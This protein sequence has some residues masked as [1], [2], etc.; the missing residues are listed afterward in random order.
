MPGT[1]EPSEWVRRWSH[2]VPVHGTVLDVACGQGRHM[3][4]F[5]SRGHGAVGIDRDPQALEA[6][7]RFGE[8]IAAD[9][10]NAAWPLLKGG[11][12][13]RFA[14]LVVTH[15]LWRRLWPTLLLSLEP[16]G[17]LLYETFAAGNAEFGKPSRADFLLQ[18]GELL[19]VCSDL[20]IVAYENGFLNHPPRL[21]QRIAAQRPGPITPWQHAPLSLE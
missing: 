13:Q 10:E 8:V 18:P 5:S 1:G 19:Q 20:H 9:I 14:A 2:L 7:G 6:A 17:I 11:V 15:Y 4:W 21:M 3:R 12:P 16:G